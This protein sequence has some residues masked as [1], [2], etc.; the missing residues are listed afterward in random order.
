MIHLAEHGDG[1][2]GVQQGH[3]LWRANHDRLGRGTNCEIDKATSPVPGGMSIT[4]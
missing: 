3:V 4:R 2:R 1:L